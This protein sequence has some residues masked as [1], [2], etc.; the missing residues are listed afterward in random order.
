MTV[1]TEPI[2]WDAVR[3]RYEGA[4]ET[5]LDIAKSIHIEQ[6]ELSRQ[7]KRRGWTMRNPARVTP[8]STGATLRRLRD[9]LQQRMHQFEGAT[10]EEGDLRDTGALLRNFEKVLE[11]EERHRKRKNRN[12]RDSRR[13]NDAERDELARRIVGLLESAGR[14]D[15]EPDSD[16]QTR[17]QPAARLAAVG[18]GGP[19][20]A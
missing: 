12:L 2:D 1:T 4:E 3:A 16:H 18:E 6:P 10:V 5:V 9:S 11:L 13:L 15:A 7:A 14:N 8:A 17:P 20:S 19:A